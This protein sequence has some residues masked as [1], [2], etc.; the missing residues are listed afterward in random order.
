MSMPDPMPSY[1]AQTPPG[2]PPPHPAPYAASA[3]EDAPLPGCG[4]EP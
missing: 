1:D 2:H 3:P 4:G